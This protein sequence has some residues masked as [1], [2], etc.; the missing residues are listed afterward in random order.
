[1]WLSCYDVRRIVDFIW[2]YMPTCL[3]Y[4]PV[5]CLPVPVLCS[6]ANKSCVSSAVD[7]LAVT[8]HVA[9]CAY[10]VA[11]VR[12]HVMSARDCHR[13]S[14][15]VVTD[16]DRP[17]PSLPGHL[18]LSHQ[19]PQQLCRCPGQPSSIFMRRRPWLVDAGHPSGPMQP[20]QPAPPL[21]PSLTYRRLPESRRFKSQTGS[22]GRR[23]DTLWDICYKADLLIHYGATENSYRSLVFAAR[24]VR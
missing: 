17:R 15:C 3:F 22:R 4:R 12:Q 5:Y 20:L 7:M 10:V 6:L 14:R 19:Q 24:R 1:M 2:Q 13:P 21:P 23:H 16:A 8:W 11:D 18:S 9:V